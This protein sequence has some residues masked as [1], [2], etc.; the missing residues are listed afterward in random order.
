[1]KT[2]KEDSDKK[3]EYIEEIDEID[4]ERSGTDIQKKIKR[5]KEKLKSCQK[6]KEEYLK[7]WQKERADF[8]NYRNEEDK[9]KKDF[10]LFIR[11]KIILEF[12]EVL[13]SLER[14]EKEIP[15]NLKSNDWVKGII[16]IQDQ[17]KNILK[18]QGVEE[19]KDKD[20]KVFNPEFHEAVEI[21]NGEDG[22]I[23]KVL[24]KGYFFDG[25]VIRP[26]KVR[27]GKKS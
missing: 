25:K 16:S 24:Q 9:R 5:I 14:A 13:D 21:D 20:N 1:M 15:K 12:L 19:I 10:S 4:E 22:K 18:K 3:I 2:K 27:V 11:G 7:G 6:E 26:A 23:L 17:L 8:I